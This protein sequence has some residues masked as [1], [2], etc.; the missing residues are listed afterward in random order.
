MLLLYIKHQ[1]P[2][3]NT[4]LVT[5]IIDN[6]I[7]YNT[8]IV[9]K[10]TYSVT[11]YIFPLER[12]HYVHKSLCFFNNFHIKRLKAHYSSLVFISFFDNKSDWT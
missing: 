9:E 12:K 5:C 3:T 10:E 11:N 1:P 4:L 8:K 7:S 6:L 2:S